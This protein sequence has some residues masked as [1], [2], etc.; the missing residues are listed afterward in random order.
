MLFVRFTVNGARSAKAD[1]ESDP[2][3]R[4]R[5]QLSLADAA[6]LPL[7]K[8]VIGEVVADL[9]PQDKLKNKKKKPKDK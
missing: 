6:G 3:V 9:A 8:P 1:E 2:R 4:L 5:Y 7:A